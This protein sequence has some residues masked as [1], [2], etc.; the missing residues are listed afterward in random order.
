[1]FRVKQAVVFSL[2]LIIKSLFY[3]QLH[4]KQDKF[5]FQSRE[6]QVT[7]SITRDVRDISKAGVSVH[8]KD[9]VP[10][11]LATFLNSLDS[12]KAYFASFRGKKY[13]EVKIFYYWHKIV[14]QDVNFNP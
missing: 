14:V 5:D 11:Q 12:V 4:L 8:L 6:S 2:V 7:L 1:M 10:H 9:A 13:E 3:F